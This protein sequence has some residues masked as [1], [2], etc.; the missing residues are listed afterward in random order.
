MKKSIILLALAMALVFAVPVLAVEGEVTSQV[1][2]EDVTEDID[3][4]TFTYADGTLDFTALL[5]EDMTAGFDFLVGSPLDELGD[6]DIALRPNAEF[7]GVDYLTLGVDGALGE[8]SD[9]IDTEDYMFLIPDEGDS[10][11]AMEFYGNVSVDDMVD[12]VTFGVDNDLVV[13]DDED[14]LLTTSPFVNY[15]MEVAPGM[16]A[17]VNN[18]ITYEVLEDDTAEDIEFNPFFNL[19]MDIDADTTL[20]ADINHT[21]TRYEFSGESHSDDIVVESTLENTAVENLALG[22]TGALDDDELLII[23][24]VLTNDNE[25]NTSFA[26][27][28]YANYAMD[29]TEELEVGSDNNVT[30]G[31]EEE[32]G[33]G[34]APFADYTMNLD[35]NL[36]F[37]ARTDIDLVTGDFD[38][39]KVFDGV[40]IEASVTYTF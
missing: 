8:E 18:S 28:L 36:C 15:A 9:A 31:D 10:T 4:G 12:N 40:S 14:E 30:F 25:F 38:D 17:G 16:T 11:Y 5:E 33:L 24:D 1:E 22:V 21:L 3:D 6:I 2:M 37:N 19:A 35:D 13:E 7:T 26:A 32:E 29:V 34:V 23:E 20:T 39:V 27:K